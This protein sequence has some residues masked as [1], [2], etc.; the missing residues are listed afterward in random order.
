MNTRLIATGCLLVA[1]A[2]LQARTSSADTPVA[3]GGDTVNAPT[4]VLAPIQVNAF[5]LGQD[6]LSTPAA[7]DVVGHDAIDQGRRKTQLNPALNRVPGVYANNGS[8]FAQN[9]RVSIRG[10]GARSAFGVRG[11]RVLVDGIPETLV[12][13][14]AQT[15]SID[16]GAIDRMEVLRGP[17]SALYGNATGGVID[18][19]TLAPG[20]GP[21]DEAEVAGG[22]NG[23][24]RE[25]LSSAHKYDKWGYAATISRLE[26]KGYR[27]HS[28][29]VKNQFTGKIERDVGTDGKLTLT[30]RLLHAPNTQDPGGVTRETARANRHAARAANLAYDA[31]QSVG[32]ETLGGVFK[33]RLSAHQNYKLHAFYTHRNFIEYLPFGSTSGGGAVTYR[34]NFFG[35]GGQTT[36]YDTLLGHHNRLVLGA[37][38]QTQQDD[39]QRYNNDFGSK[40][41]LRLDQNETATN[42][43]VF[44]Q[45]E[46]AIISDLK[47]TLGARYD[48]LNFDIADHFRS[49]GNQS[50]SRN[51]HR[52]SF[53]F[54]LNY[55]WAHRQHVY[56]NIANAFES[57]TFT[58]FANPTGSG[59]FNPSLGPQKA[60]NYEIGAKGEFGTR[61]RY[62]IDAFRVNV[63]D[64][65]TAYAEQG[66]RTFYQNSGRSRRQGIES[67]LSFDLGHHVSTTLAYTVAS[68]QYSDYV[69]ENGNDY[70]GHRLPGIPEQTAFGELAWQRAN[71]GYAAV[72]VHWAGSIYA[73]DANT[74]RVAPHT[75]VDARVGKTVPAGAHRLTVYAGVDNLFD[76]DYFDNIRINSYGGRYFE[77]APGRSIY[78]GLK[79]RL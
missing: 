67:K 34:R 51:Y 71:I 72:D 29:V 76:D 60:V 42:V 44:A 11:V 2:P 75:V 56:A 65:I 70:S 62:Q 43:G 14:Q 38:T 13:G 57:P 61:G 30:T 74:S 73:N 68:Y 64:A 45:D 18:I 21:L 7:V 47:A 52:A 26:Q 15:D 37:D 22:S 12:D 24:H 32:Q 58:E 4:R 79:F 35:G 59:G 48:W 17:F 27:Q 78:A 3:A 28:K 25:S 50:G 63:R 19:T 6:L 33:D 55:A 39:R 23:Y 36:R 77:P 1:A 41:A 53:N 10:F 69:D 40:G 49:D 31:R 54:G 66:D 8:N 16:L 46:F 9:L 20:D 5:R